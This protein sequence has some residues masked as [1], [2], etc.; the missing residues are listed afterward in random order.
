MSRSLFSYAL[1]FLFFLFIAVI[2][3]TAP[4]RTSWHFLVAA[5]I[6]GAL[7]LAYLYNYVNL[8][9]R[10]ILVVAIGLRAIFFFLPPSLSDDAYR[11]VWDGM[12]QADGINPYL[13]TPS[14]EELSLY[15]DEPIY[16]L[17]NSQDYYSVYPPI[18]Q[19]I[20]AVGGLAYDYGW[21]VSYYTIKALLI[22]FEIGAL[23]LLAQLISPGLL[24]LYAWH[25]LVIMETAGQAH[26][27]SAMLLFLV[28]AVWLARRNRGYATAIAL[29]CAGWV[30]LYP[31]VFMPLL[32][33]RFGLRG[34]TAGGAAT[35][36]LVAPFFHPDLLTNILDSLNLYV[37][38]FEFNAGVYYFIKKIYLIFTGDDWSKLIGPALRQIFLVGLPVIYALD[39]WKKWPLEKTMLVIYGFFLLCATTIH[40]W[41]FLGLLLLAPMQARMPWHWF[42][43]SALALGTYLL[44]IDG[45]YWPFVNIGWWGWAVLALYYHRDKP[46]SWLQEIQQLRA[47]R[48]VDAIESLLDGN[49][50]GNKVLDLG[51]GEGYVGQE[52][53]R[54]WSADVM[55]ADVV[56]M[57]RTGLP[58]R[59]YGG[60]R[61][62]FSG[63]TFDATV[64]YFVLHHT[65]HP[66]QVIREAFR[67]TKNRVIVVE[68][69]YEHTWDLK[70]LTFVDVWVN[71]IR[72]A[73][74]MTEQEEFLSF[75][76]APDWQQLFEKNGWVV[77]KQTRRGRWIHKQHFF[78]LEPAKTG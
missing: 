32:W 4:D 29:A 7:L 68:S 69:V 64:L 14:D 76:K 40:P 56:D 34:I 60:R 37:R 54:R 62:P 57:N 49:S 21:E 17:L 24:I 36:L 10:T 18:S 48:K 66:E 72:S 42:W 55:L 46:D 70:L 78:V 52:I 8:S 50:P 63:K 74:K 51:A 3:W 11:Y 35:I 22:G 25:P 1:L 33:R 31:F 61:L 77:V 47:S 71:R 26:T 19:F 39:Y 58:H 28:S 44:Y 9:V 67:M 12:L 75:K 73:G 41:Y 15:H 59:T 30:K 43:V 16:A 6:G 23:L 45:P 20:F 27:E 53:S 5:S 13:Y 65:E 2:A 38:L